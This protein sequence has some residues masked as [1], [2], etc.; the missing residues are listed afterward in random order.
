MILL[1]MLGEISNLIMLCGGYTS[2]DEKS[3]HVLFVLI[4]LIK[5]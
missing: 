4:L 5:L 2:S 1:T 3:S